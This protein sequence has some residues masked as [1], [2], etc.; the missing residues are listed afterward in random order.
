MSVPVTVFAKKSFSNTNIAIDISDLEKRD[1]LLALYNGTPNLS[2][3]ASEQLKH[4]F[5][6][7]VPYDFGNPPV[8]VNNRGRLRL[9]EIAEE[10]F[11]DHLYYI[12]LG[13]GTRRIAVFLYG[14]RKG[15]EDWMLN[16]ENP[17]FMDA[18]QYDL[19]YGE[20][21]AE[22][23]IANLRKEHETRKLATRLELILSLMSI[24][25]DYT[26]SDLIDAKVGLD[27][28]SAALDRAKQSLDEMENAMQN[29]TKVS[30]E[31]LTMFSIKPYSSSQTQKGLTEIQQKLLVNSTMPRSKL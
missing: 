6:L 31:L 3:T 16:G 10:F 8:S 25:I 30:K 21:S 17:S 2:N 28:V 11:S 24:R 13:G 26:K 20:G 23:I 7:N 1:I 29:I 22:K 5:V 15:S 18:T 19:E 14:K 27:T 4:E 9:D 12:N